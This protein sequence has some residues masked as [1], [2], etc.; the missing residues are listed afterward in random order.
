MTFPFIDHLCFELN[1]S[2]NPLPADYSISK[3]S[4]CEPYSRPFPPAPPPF[5]STSHRQL[6]LKLFMGEDT[7]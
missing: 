3:R 1:H 7:N 2:N 4:I 5:K 6:P